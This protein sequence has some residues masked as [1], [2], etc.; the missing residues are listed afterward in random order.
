MI[1]S[2]WKTCLIDIDRAS[3]FTGDDVDQ[4][5]ALVDLGRA[6]EKVV[7]WVP[8]IT[9][10]ALNIYVQRVASTATVPTILH[11]ANMKDTGG[12]GTWTSEAW[13]TTAGTG[14]YVITC[15]CLGGIQY[16]R[17]RATSTQTTTDKTL[18]L[19]GVRS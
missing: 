4:Y 16:V 3:Q 19:R 12:N 14:D 10:S 2:E 5:S 13:A 17:I 1:E 11:M 18:Y 9:S 6:Y 7:I 15:D 8:T